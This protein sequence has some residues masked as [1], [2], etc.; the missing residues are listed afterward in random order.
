MDYFWI[1]ATGF[2]YI[3][4]LKLLSDSRKGSLEASKSGNAFILSTL[5]FLSLF[6][7]NFY[8]YIYIYILN[9]FVL[10]SKSRIC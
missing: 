3:G 1:I 8:K 6:F 7:F 2:S 5:L 9:T 4:I 10:T